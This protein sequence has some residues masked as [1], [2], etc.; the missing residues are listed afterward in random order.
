MDA[1]QGSVKVEVSRQDG[2]RS[3]RMRMLR[4]RAFTFVLALGVFCS[5]AGTLSLALK[6]VEAW[7]DSGPIQVSWDGMRALGRASWSVDQTSPEDHS[8]ETSVSYQLAETTK[9]LELAQSQK[10][11][12]PKARFL[13]VPVFSLNTQSVLRKLVFSSQAETLRRWIF[14]PNAMP[15][16]N[17]DFRQPATVSA[18]ASPSKAAP[19]QAKFAGQVGV[20]THATKK[21]SLER[22]PNGSGLAKRVEVPHQEVHVGEVKGKVETPSPSGPMVAEKEVPPVVP[23]IIPDASVEEPTSVASVSA[24]SK[25]EPRLRRV[26][27]ES[28][29]SAWISMTLDGYPE[30]L[31]SQA[32][33]SIPSAASAEGLGSQYQEWLNSQRSGTQKGEEAPSQGWVA[34]W[35]PEG[36]LV[37]VKG[38]SSVKY[39]TASG[40]ER[41]GTDP[42]EKFFVAARVSEGPAVVQLLSLDD[43]RVLSAAGIP[44]MKDRMTQVD[45]RNL[46]KTRVWGSLLDSE[47]Q[48][49]VGVPHAEVKLVGYANHLTVTD[50]QGL[51]DLGEVAVPTGLNVFL[52][53]RTQT[54]FVHR[55]PV[56]NAASS[57]GLS[58]F[59]FSNDRLGRWMGNLEGG[60]SA[61]SAMIVASMKQ[62]K[63]LGGRPVIKSFS[64][65]RTLKP[66]TYW[67]TAKDQLLEPNHLLNTD[68]KTN[69]V[70]WLGVEISSNAVLAGL[71]SARGRWV[72]SKWL[73]TSPGVITVTNFEE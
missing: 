10:F 33:L 35:I 63:L 28:S 5:S 59:Y 49:P 45:F 20:T 70:Q 13:R 41:A 57:E 54:G 53:A 1:A 40:L 22:S 25:D 23:A 8:V 34:G 7:R 30:I 27:Q 72:K 26:S 52:E 43:Q 4:K 32:N 46:Q 62:E 16:R 55:Y 48:L 37:Q 68:I 15:E 31:F 17:R 60:L 44:V 11:S 36:A 18:Q 50:D 19:K 24:V 9:A 58:L 2:G 38:S 39:F 69:Y 71:Q 12:F 47:Q 6:T 3:Q 56:A 67:L 64:G 66:E 61:R 29:G 21:P 14:T 65:D 73:P 42:G 51:F